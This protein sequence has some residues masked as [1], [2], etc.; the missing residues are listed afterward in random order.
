MSERRQGLTLKT[1][2]DL[3]F[4]KK[5]PPKQMLEG[6]DELFSGPPCPTYFGFSLV[7]TGSSGHISRACPMRCKLVAVVVAASFAVSIEVPAIG[8]SEL[9][10]TRQSIYTGN[11]SAQDPEGR[12]TAVA[13]RF[14]KSDR[15]VYHSQDPPV[16]TKYTP[17][18]IRHSRCPY[19]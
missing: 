9:P 13:E 2:S 7:P 17:T 15:A 1:F 4:K 12:S 11:L 5:P 6:G 14:C 8:I 18:E 16:C 3:Q 10:G 19:Q